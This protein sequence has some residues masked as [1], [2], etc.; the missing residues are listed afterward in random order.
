[1][2]EG[3][4][5]SLSKTHPILGLQIL[6]QEWAGKDVAHVPI[7]KHLGRGLLFHGSLASL[8][9][10]AAPANIVVSY[11]N[12]ES[13]GSTQALGD[14]QSTYGQKIISFGANFKHPL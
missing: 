9:L 2:N 13:T 1:M 12:S 5:S 8:T 14:A 11:S 6:A 10:M 7:K 4:F 3:E